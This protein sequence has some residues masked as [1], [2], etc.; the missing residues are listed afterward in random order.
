M[1]ATRNTDRKV[2][3][4]QELL[5]DIQ[6]KSTTVGSSGVG[7]SSAGALSSSKPP[8]EDMSVRAAKLTERVSIIDQKLNANQRYKNATQRKGF[9]MK[10]VTD[11][12]GGALNMMGGREDRYERRIMELSR[13]DDED[14][15]VVVD[16]DDGKG[17]YSFR[18][19]FFVLFLFFR[20]LVVCKI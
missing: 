10:N 11:K 15:V 9:T 17:E 20:I 7:G 19:C 4:T 18:F 12:G 13:D 8:L 6:N 16:D 3:T 1:N 14:V 2:K 5:A